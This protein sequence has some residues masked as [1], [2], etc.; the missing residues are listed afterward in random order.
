MT[1]GFRQP[2]TCAANTLPKDYAGPMCQGSVFSFVIRL[3]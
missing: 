3:P 1:Q 2:P